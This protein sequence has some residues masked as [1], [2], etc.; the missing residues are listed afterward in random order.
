MSE[1]SAGTL[2]QNLREPDGSA[3]SELNR[4]RVPTSIEPP[5][6]D[7]VISIYCG[8]TLVV[9]QA[10]PIKWPSRAHS[11]MLGALM[12]HHHRSEAQS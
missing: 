7:V 5:G 11:T 3:P 9:V 10:A 1:S 6:S 4:L 12:Q 2:Y 8:H